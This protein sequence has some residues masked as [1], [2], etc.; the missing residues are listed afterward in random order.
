MTWGRSE[1]YNHGDYSINKKILFV[2]IFLS[3]QMS[4]RTNV[5]PDKCLS[6]QMSVRTN[7]CPDKCLSGQVSVQTII[8]TFGMKCLSEH[9]SIPLAKNVCPNINLYLWKTWFLSVKS[10]VPLNYPKGEQRAAG[11]GPEASMLN[12]PLFLHWKYI[13]RALGLQAR[14]QWF[15]SRLRN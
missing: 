10:F 7:V 14:G 13:G 11:G 5:C 2:I 9:K 15:E 12:L 8:Y 3:G 6:G 4:V 1:N